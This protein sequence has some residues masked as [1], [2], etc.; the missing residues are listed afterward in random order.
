MT[1]SCVDDTCISDHITLN[2]NGL[3]TTTTLNLNIP[4]LL[5]KG[6]S[7]NSNILQLN[8]GADYQ[9]LNTDYTIVITSGSLVA[10]KY[11]VLPPISTSQGQQ[12]IIKRLYADGTY[13]FII[14][15]QGGETLETIIDGVITLNSNLDCTSLVCINSGWVIIT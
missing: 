8:D 7:F 6:A 15:P 2:G 4:A 3:T 11:I 1:K 14:K 5:N 13:N 12:L 9:V 10:D